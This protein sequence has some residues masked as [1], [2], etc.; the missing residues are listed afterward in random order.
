MS[1]EKKHKIGQEG[2]AGLQAHILLPELKAMVYKKFKAWLGV[3]LCTLHISLD[4]V[5]Q[6]AGKGFKVPKGPYYFCIPMDLMEQNGNNEHH[7]VYESRSHQALTSM[8]DP[9]AWNN[10]IKPLMMVDLTLKEEDLPDD[11]LDP[12]WGNGQLTPVSNR[13]SKH[14]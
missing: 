7:G 13:G 12:N 5:Q 3:K 10:E 9:L 4:M 11:L 1:P 6:A 2:V 14:A 8:N